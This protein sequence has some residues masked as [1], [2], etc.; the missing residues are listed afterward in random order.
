M[1]GR[2]KPGESGN[3]GGRKPGSLA[4]SGKL[5]ASIEK[6]IPDILSV[7]VE[8]AK[9]GDTAAAKLLLDRCLPVLR[10]VD[11]PTPLAIGE[12]SA[13][14]AGAAA[15]VLTGLAA[16]TLSPDQA[17]S[18]AGVLSALARVEETVGLAARVA[19]LESKTQ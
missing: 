5:R 8:Q 15:A 4:R 19:A 18:V 12:G 11:Q 1:G 7:L 17:Q 14:L 10:P 2:F 9:I 16:G 3:P 13:D 6:D